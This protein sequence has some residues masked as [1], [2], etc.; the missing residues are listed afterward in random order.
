M[1]LLDPLTGAL[2][3]DLVLAA[4]GRAYDRR[5]LNDF[6]AD[7]A[8]LGLPLVSPHDMTTPMGSALTP[9]PAELVA[10]L[11]QLHEDA[12]LAPAGGQ[13]TFKSLETLKA[14]FDVLDPLGDLLARTL[15]EW[16]TPIVMVIG[17]ET[18]HVLVLVANH[19]AIPI[20]GSSSDDLFSF[21][22]IGKSSLLAATMVS[23]AMQPVKELEL[24]DRTVGVFTICDHLGRPAMKPLSGRLKQTAGGMPLEPHGYVATIN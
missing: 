3:D 23:Q 6:I 10:E 7:R 4:D 2:I 9:A 13:T 19:V 5:S 18:S 16:Q 8:A 20:I 24:Q 22:M 14:L 11:R 17:N 21:P 15:E 1:Q 12:E